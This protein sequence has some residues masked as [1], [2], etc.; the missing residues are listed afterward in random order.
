MAPTSSPPEINIE[1]EYCPQ[2]IIDWCNHIAS[3]DHK[4]RGSSSRDLSLKAKKHLC[5][6]GWK[7]WYIDKKYKWELRYTSPN[8][9]KTYISLRRA[10]ESC[11]AEGLEKGT[12][13]IVPVL[14]EHPSKPKKK[15]QRICKEERQSDAEEHSE[16]E[17][18]ERGRVVRR[19]KR[20]WNEDGAQGSGSSQRNPRK[21][22]SWL[23]DNKVVALHSR[24]F[25]GGANNVVKKGKLMHCGIACDCCGLVFSISRFEAHAECN[26]HRPSATII[27]EDGRS[28]LDCQ[29]QVLSSN[30]KVVNDSVCSHCR[31]G[32][33]VMLCDCCPSSFHLDCLGL[34]SVPDGDWF[35]PRCCCKICH[36]PRC[37]EDCADDLDDNSALICDQCERKYH[38]G[39]L[40]ARGFTRLGN[41]PPRKIWFC[42]RSCEKL[43]FRLQDLIGKENLV[44]ED[45]LIWTL[46]KIVES[47]ESEE[48]DPS[49][50]EFEGLSKIKKK[51]NLAVGLLHECFDPLIDAFSG[52]DIVAD[53]IFSR[54]L[55]FSRLDFSGF[56]TVVLERNNELISVATIRIFG[57]S[58]AEIPLVG[59]WSKFRRLGMCRILMNEIEKKLSDLGVRRLV[60]PSTHNVI[61]TW[62]N[63]FGLERM[64]V[65]D[66][67]QFLEHTFLDFQDTIMCHKPLL[68]AS[69][70][71]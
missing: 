65:S 62:T 5:A 29:N 37:K 22:I 21:I 52:R 1:P 9:G 70:N 48:S 42:T 19:A 50:R 31:F 41:H 18:E 30:A 57:Q 11:I 20:V 56:Y 55:E 61:H 15:K 34:D 39:C 8:N 2:A 47:D 45:N 4:P 3:Q 43:Y 36:K 49:S 38:V 46:L 17:L 7:F 64:T 33:D 69:I 28:L 32:G 16:S 6:L 68:N 51:L 63:S 44:G 67:F 10:C 58:V 66:K 27:L 40:K 14:Q 24:V 35:C 25:C 23:L 59:T 54:G 13:Q 26:K 60:L 53:V 12:P 71:Y